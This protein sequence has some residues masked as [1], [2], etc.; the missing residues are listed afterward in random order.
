MTLRAL[1]NALGKT[2]HGDACESDVSLCFA[3]DSGYLPLFRVC[4]ASLAFSGNFL[5][6]QIVIYTDDPIVAADPSVKKLAD[7]VSLLEGDKKVLLYGL[8]RENVH[9]R[10]RMDWNRGTFL[11]WM[12][13]EPHETETAVFL[14]VDMIFLRRFADRLLSA[15]ETEFSCVPQFREQMIKH[16]DGSFREPK[17]RR[18][19]LNRVLRGEYWDKL[20][21]NVNSGVMVVR[22]PFLNDGFFGEIT[23]HA[24]ARKTINEQL[25]FTEYFRTRAG[26]LTMLPGRFNF[27]ESHFSQMPWADQQKLLKN[28]DVLHYAGTAKPWKQVPRHANFRPSQ[29]LWHWHRSLADLAIP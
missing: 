5:D 21:T 10:D 17:E 23:D 14:D 19:M 3:F 20:L 25:Q 26:R 24:R 16:D 28:I 6:S 2:V 8:A 22:K 18:E 27:Q 15:S 29:A 7:R 1:A 12:I 13:F 9:Q 11:K 4:I